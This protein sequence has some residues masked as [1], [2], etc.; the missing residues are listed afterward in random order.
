MAVYQYRKFKVSL[1]D[2][3]KKSQGL[4]VGDIVRR[5]YM[6]SNSIIYSLM[7]VLEVGKTVIS[8]TK[9][10]QWFIGALLDGDVPK[11]DELLDFVRVTNLWDA[12]RLGA[13]YLTSSDDEAPYI[14]VID[15]I[16]KEKSLCYPS[17]L[18]DLS[19]KDDFYQY[20]TVCGN[21]L[22]ASYNTSVNDVNRICKLVRNNTTSDGS[23]FGI[24]Q[25]I[26]KK[27]STPSRVLIAYKSRASRQIDDVKGCLEYTDESKI[28]GSFSINFTTE[29][30][31]QL[32]VVTLEN[33]E[34][35]S[36]TFKLDLTSLVFGDSIEIADFNIILLSSISNFVDGMKMRIGKLNGVSDPVFGNLEDYGVYA[37]RFYAT[38]QV[39]ISGTI[40]A[41][42]ENGFGCTFYA[43]KIHKNVVI[44]SLACDFETSTS[45]VKEA[46]PV[47]SGE[48]YSSQK[49][50][51]LNAQTN[52]WMKEHLGKQYCF[53]FWAKN[54]TSCKVLVSQN[55]YS[56][57]IIELIAGDIW[58][59]Y[60]VPF[61]IQEGIGDSIQLQMKLLPSAGT[62][63]FTAPQIESGSY[64]T[65][66]QA[67]DDVLSY[68]EDY[69]AWFS[70]GGIG[71]TIQNPLLKLNSDGSIST[72][73][74]SFNING[75][76][77]G[78][79]ANGRL[80]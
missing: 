67:T 17:G 64:A 15:G 20:G 22:T 78:S 35:C 44:N 62:L 26:T 47:G 53:S 11:S 66:Y 54:E 79:F 24:K 18:N 30:K 63:L 56:L 74:N 28:D 10:K 33:T 37:Q 31:Y 13:L 41:G 46:S 32:H 50:I 61:V 51:V 52:S 58:R 9:S 65:Q 29:W 71:G 2:D 80:S 7:C 6:D 25:N 48:V 21:F 73:N 45:I 36:H 49:E 16:G 27:L 4:H 43:G 77:T 34:E 72:K 23:F 68:V 70:K 1:D 69:G 57:K 19:W 3:S 55:D 14:D 38:K 5:Q 39:N 59:R 76:G 12:N 75:D 42:D 60:T 8:E 40:T